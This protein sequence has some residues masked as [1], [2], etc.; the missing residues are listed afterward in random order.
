MPNDHLDRED[1][2]FICA[3]IVRFAKFTPADY[4]R[5]TAEDPHTFFY[6]LRGIEGR[7]VI[8]G[9]EASARLLAMA[10]RQLKLHPTFA[11]RTTAAALQEKI[12][13]EF[14]SRFLV[15]GQPTTNENIRG[16]LANAR[17]KLEASFQT[18]R[19]FIPCSIFL[20]ESVTRLPIGPVEFVK[21]ETFM[22]EYEEQ[23][24]ELRGRY[25]KREPQNAGA[26]AAA[27]NSLTDCVTRHFNDFTWVAIVQVEPAD[28]DRSYRK[29]A[30]LAR[31]ALNI[32]R[33]TYGRPY[34]YRM[35]TADER[36]RDA[37]SACLW[38]NPDGK[39]GYSFTLGGN[40]HVGG[41]N[42]HDLIKDDPPF[43][44]L[45][46]KTLSACAGFDDGPHLC[47]RFI[48]ALAWFGDAVTEIDPA[49]RIVKLV[50]AIEEMTVTGKAPGVTKTVCTRAARWH[51]FQTKDTFRTSYNHIEMLYDWR[52]KIVHG[53]V[54][55]LDDALVAVSHEAE[56]TVR[57]LLVTGLSFF[58]MLGLED[59][60]ID[61]AELN[62]LYEVCEKDD[63]ERDRRTQDKD[64]PQN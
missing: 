52:S 21:R 11:R 10:V 54:S 6:S 59:R 58:E 63:Q 55:P 20:S 8:I 45:A 41:G 28:D 40:D 51:Q 57:L 34:T 4:K 27:G 5:V 19:H 60:R 62:R 64:R 14:S 25:E 48:E 30:F 33:L 43:Y 22:A 37:Q 44:K 42:W 36:G 38:L 50:T 26:A 13:S 46:K 49:P 7:M 1:F 2:D 9:R 61:A 31:S 35:R 12:R 24:A 32:I 29:A 47:V 53:S 15:E 39:F 23:F 16:M 56:A 3:E 17:G 18:Q